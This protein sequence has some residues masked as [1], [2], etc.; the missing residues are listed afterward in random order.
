MCGI[1]GSWKLNLSRKFNALLIESINY[2]GPD[3]ISNFIDDEADI[4]LSHAR[5][6]IIDL[7]DAGTQPI[8]SNDNNYVL[9]FNG[10]IYNHIELR[11]LLFKKFGFN[12]WKGHSDSETLVELISHYGIDYSISLLNGMFAF[13]LWDVRKKELFVAR[14][15]FGQKPLYYFTTKNGVCFSSEIKSF[16]KIPDLT[17]EISYES[18]LY[19]SNFNYI[20]SPLTI[21]EKISKVEPGS[22][23]RFS[24]NE[25]CVFS[26]VYRFNPIL[27]ECSDT[28]FS[29]YSEENFDTLIHDVVDSHLLSDVEVS[30]FLSGGFD[31]SALAIA[32][33]NSIKK[34]DTF[35]ISH[36]SSNY[37]DES[38]YAESV[39]KYLGLHHQ[40]INITNQ[41]LDSAFFEMPYYF[42]EPFADASQI[43]TA[44]LS[45]HVSQRYKVSL[46]GDGAY[47]LFYGYNRYKYL[48]YITKLLNNFPNYLREFLF[49]PVTFVLSSPYSK[50]IV[51]LV[52]QLTRINDLN[53]KL[54][55]FTSSMTSSSLIECI[56]KIISNP[57]C[58]KSISKSN[59]FS[60]FLNNKSLSDP[61]LS[62]DALR[63]LDLKYYLADDIL[64][65]I[66]RS[67]MRHG[68]EGR[69]PFLDL[70]FKLFTNNLGSNIVNNINCSKWIIKNFVYKHIPA[71]IMNRPKQGFGLPFAEILLDKESSWVLPNIHYSESLSQFYS[72]SY[73]IDLW[74]RFKNGEH[75][76]FNSVWNFLIFVSWYRVNN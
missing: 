26:D 43:P 32:Y 40:N 41:D 59:L 62:V 8:I 54:I 72:P 57:I 18:F 64:T 73:G 35:S 3:G 48:F 51:K 10:E 27:L 49:R 42:D 4:Y 12:K 15:Y 28:K 2:R 29:Y 31:S 37:I 55:K 52:E 20:P 58:N 11:N 46:M 9:T 25:T 66:D 44:I 24:L 68:L 47:E 1:A 71:S 61:F 60:S 74:R 56:L 21:Y 33:S 23:I 14:D 67:A 38:Y 30:A 65:K 53:I 22:Y 70:R 39:S 69:C 7:S 75:Y 19:F 17:F 36:G 34:V 5:L 76:L 13:G 45:K 50:A 6:S 63:D 16:K